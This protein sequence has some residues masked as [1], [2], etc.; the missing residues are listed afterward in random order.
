MVAGTGS[1]WTGTSFSQDQDGKVAAKFRKLMGIKGSA[2]RGSA[3]ED[4]PTPGG[5][6]LSQVSLTGVYLYM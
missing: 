2:S 3:D 4:V 5:G 1:Q 6:R